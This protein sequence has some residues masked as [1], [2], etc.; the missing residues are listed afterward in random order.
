MGLFGKDK[1]ND[2]SD[3]YID[4]DA[5]AT[6]GKKKGTR[7]AFCTECETWYD[8]TNGAEVNKHAH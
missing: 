4:P 8:S 6:I 1:K 7:D 3:K 5:A 2:D